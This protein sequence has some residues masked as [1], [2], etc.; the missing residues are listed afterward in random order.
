MQSSSIVVMCA[1]RPTTTSDSV[2]CI[3]DIRIGSSNDNEYD[4]FGKKLSNRACSS[5]G[6]TLSLAAGL[7]CLG[8]SKENRRPDQGDPVDRVD[9]GD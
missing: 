6:R 7:M 5:D 2:G 3:R 4:H 1:C 9:E 8:D